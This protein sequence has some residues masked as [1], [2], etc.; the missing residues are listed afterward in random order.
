T[1]NQ[2]NYTY[3]TLFRS[4]GVEDKFGNDAPAGSSNNEANLYTIGLKHRFVDRRTTTY[5]TYSSLVNGY[6]AHYSLGAGG[7]GLPTRNYVRSEE[8][9]SE[10][11]S[12]AYL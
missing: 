4:A 3:T 6:W 12:L 5:L 1:P 8:H 7:H 11:Q 9:T 2:H 10:L